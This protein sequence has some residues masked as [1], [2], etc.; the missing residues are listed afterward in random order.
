MWN[1]L[2]MHVY[3]KAAKRIGF[4]VCN[5]ILGETPLSSVN[6]IVKSLILY[7]KQYIFTC[8]KQNKVLNFT[9]LMYHL[10]FKHEIG[11]SIIIQNF[12]IS[13]IFQ[14]ILRSFGH[15]GCLFL[16]FD[17]YEFVLFLYIQI[18]WAT[19]IYYMYLICK[20]CILHIF[21]Y[22]ERSYV[23]MSVRKCERV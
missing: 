5:I 19:M 22:Y 6:I 7:T 2:S 1:N 12:E 4:N 21:E 10:K 23:C 3:R 17:N 13:E 20:L 16:I 8:L 18:H 14:R 11:K 15:H 9:G